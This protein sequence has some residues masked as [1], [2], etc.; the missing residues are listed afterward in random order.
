MSRADDILK[1]AGKINRNNNELSDYDVLLFMADKI[2]EVTN[3]RNVVLKGGLALLD[4]ILSC[5]PE[6]ER[7]TRD[8]DLSIADEGTYD[9]IFE[10]ILE[11]FNNNNIGLTF[12]INKHRGRRG[13]GEGYDFDVSTNFGGKHKVGIDMQIAQN[14]TIRTV[15]GNRIR[16]ATYDSY[17]ML[18]DKISAVSSEHIF[19]RTKD[20]YDIYVLSILQD[21][22]L[23]ELVN[24]IMQ[25]RPE[26]RENAILMFRPDTI[27][28]LVYAY[29]K[30]DG[31]RAKPDFN[32][33]YRVTSNF[34][35]GSL[36]GL[37]NQVFSPDYLW[38]GGTNN[39]IIRR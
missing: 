23:N 32:T 34:V 38:K 12:T 29:D 3:G 18:V 10:N 31:I 2:F 33:V 28:K 9:V 37:H 1:L 8:I 36:V 24:R 30:L 16:L 21:Y 11:I 17:S 6:L 27:D 25:K 20:I 13:T 5:N 26:L 19:R 14:G 4:R 35:S 15:P 7:V 22:S 39:W